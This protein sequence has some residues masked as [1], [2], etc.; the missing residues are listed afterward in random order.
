MSG[1]NVRPKV[2]VPE[3]IQEACKAAQGHLAVVEATAML[4]AYRGNSD[5]DE[6]ISGRSYEGV[7]RGGNELTQPE[8]LAMRPE[9]RIG[10]LIVEFHSLQRSL[11]RDALRFRRV[12]ENLALVRDMTH[13][14]NPEEGESRNI[15]SGDCVNCGHHCVGLRDDR[16]KSGR[17]PACYMWRL[18][19]DGEERPRETEDVA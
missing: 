1:G 2:L 6:G 3:K 5:C 12:A 8:R 19:H 16:R 15:G 4:I 18:R 9:D 7:N 14:T 17:C 13:D 10:A 11:V